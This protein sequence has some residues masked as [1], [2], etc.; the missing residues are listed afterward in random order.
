VPLLF[1]VLFSESIYG[2]DI[3]EY[4]AEYVSDEQLIDLFNK[5]KADKE[6]I[7]VLSTHAINYFYTLRYYF[8]NRPEL[9]RALSV[10]FNDLMML[11]GFY[12][13]LTARHVVDG[14]TAVKLA[15]YTLTHAVIGQSQFYQRK[16]TQTAY[17]NLC[18]ELER[19]IINHYADVTLDN[20][21]EFLVCCAIT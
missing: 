5:L 14:P 13:K 8:K 20:K 16:V 4:V 10:H 6:A 3:R 15:I 11:D 7:C 12:D 19:I 9:L 17:K 21:L 2:L 1:K 18:L